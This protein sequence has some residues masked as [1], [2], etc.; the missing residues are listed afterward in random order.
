MSK[1]KSKDQNNPVIDEVR[2]TSQMRDDRNV[3]SLNVLAQQAY[4]NDSQSGCTQLTNVIR[5]RFSL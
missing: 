5:R 2:M 3:K 1:Q 4:S